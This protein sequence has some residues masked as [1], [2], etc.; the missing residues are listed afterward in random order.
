ME[1]LDVCQCQVYYIRN[2]AFRVHKY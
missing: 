2:V 1:D